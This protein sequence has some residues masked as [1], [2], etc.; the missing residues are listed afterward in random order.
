MDHQSLMFG[1]ITYICHMMIIYFAQTKLGITDSFLIICLWLRA[2]SNDWCNSMPIRL[3]YNYVIHNVHKK[4]TLQKL[5][6]CQSY[7]M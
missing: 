1:P 4:I 7:T 3:H 2:A 5:F 6:M